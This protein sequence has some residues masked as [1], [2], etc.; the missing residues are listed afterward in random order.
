MYRQALRE[1]QQEQA[2]ILRRELDHLNLSIANA[3]RPWEWPKK[4]IEKQLAERE[5][6]D[7]AFEQQV[8]EWEREQQ[9][10]EAMIELQQEV[11]A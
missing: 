10:I 5:A 7:A 9:A 3:A 4:L 6:A 11:A 2:E 1:G 8:I